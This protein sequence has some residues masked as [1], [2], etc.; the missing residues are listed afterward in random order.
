VKPQTP[1]LDE[2]L[3]NEFGPTMT[4]DEFGKI[5]KKATRSLYNDLSRGTFPIPSY[6]VGSRHVVSTHD[7]IEF[8]HTRKLAHEASDV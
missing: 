8:M 5:V 3:L 1:N 4:L 2:Y 6:K 7:V